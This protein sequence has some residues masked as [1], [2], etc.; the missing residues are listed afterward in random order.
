[1]LRGSGNMMSA[2]R[3]IQPKRGLEEF[4]D[5]TVLEGKPLETSGRAWSI[6]EIRSKSL[7]DLQKLWIVLMKERNMLLTCRLLAKSMGGRMTHPERLVKVRTS[8][9]RIKEV[10]A[11]RERDAK[12]VALLEFEKRKASNYYAFPQTNP[13]GLQLSTEEAPSET[14]SSTPSQ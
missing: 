5:K 9:A 6:K 13:L 12:E 10:I 2:A 11:E 14:T 8:M 4:I 1:M 7:S 3:K